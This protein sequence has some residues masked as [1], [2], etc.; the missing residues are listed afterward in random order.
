MKTI[1]KTLGTTAVAAGA[2]A[3]SAVP[4]TVQA[5]VNSSDVPSAANRA[6]QTSGTSSV[7]PTVTNGQHVTTLADRKIIP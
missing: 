3:L 1:S 5:V 4:I 7:G 2:L 6:G